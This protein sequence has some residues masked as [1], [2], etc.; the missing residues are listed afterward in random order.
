[1]RDNPTE[2]AGGKIKLCHLL[3]SSVAAIAL[4]PNLGLQKR[5]TASS[6]V[7]ASS[8]GQQHDR[9]MCG[10][11]EQKHTHNRNVRRPPETDRQYE[12]D[13]RNCSTA[14]VVRVRVDASA[15]QARADVITVSDHLITV[16]S[17]DTHPTYNTTEQLQA[18][19]ATLSVACA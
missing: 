12:K 17:E 18:H 15:T 11:K 14:Q 5:S 13:L 7:R 1:M 8:D 4:V 10:E 6:K 19:K 3:L 16:C 2:S 9:H